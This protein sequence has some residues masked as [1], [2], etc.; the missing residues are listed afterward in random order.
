MATQGGDFST[1]PSER[2]PNHWI[3]R[4]LM[5]R[6]HAMADQFLKKI[7]IISYLAHGVG[8]HGYKLM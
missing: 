7:A 2:L 1:L 8:K 6:L 3:M 4:C 5:S